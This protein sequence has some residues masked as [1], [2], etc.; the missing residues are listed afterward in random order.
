MR[1][2]LGSCNR[3]VTE[4]LL[5][6]AHIE[7]SVEEVGGAGV[8]EHMGRE[9]A[10]KF[11][12]FSGLGDEALDELGS[13][14]AAVGV[15]EESRVI[16]GEGYPVAEIIA[17]QVGEQSVEEEYDALAVALAMDMDGAFFQPE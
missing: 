10:G 11:G 5:R 8:A 9:A 13:G 2:D 7:A 16:G 4:K 15:D 6:I 3:L 1:I 17:Q 14:A 12:V